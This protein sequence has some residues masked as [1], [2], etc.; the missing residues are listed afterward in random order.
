MATASRPTLVGS[1]SP[2]ALRNWLTWA[3]PS[4]VLTP[5]YK[6]ESGPG[7]RRFCMKSAQRPT[8]GGDGYRVALHSQNVLYLHPLTPDLFLF[9]FFF[10]FR[11][12]IKFS[13][14]QEVNHLPTAEI[15][16]VL[17]TLIP[18]L[19]ILG[20][21]IRIQIALKPVWR[22]CLTSALPSKRKLFSGSHHTSP[23]RIGSTFLPM[24]V[25]V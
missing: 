19:W 2:C 21:Q 25:L 1:E 10:K 9:L 15:E 12:I 11:S 18:F 17:C 24:H 8:G 5:F 6:S 7:L 23:P 4:E 14:I 22:A 3:S 13:N 16:Q 20:L